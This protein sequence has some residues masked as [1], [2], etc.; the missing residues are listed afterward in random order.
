M[1]VLITGI[2]G[3][4]GSH[5]ADALSN[6]PD[7]RLSGTTLQPAQSLS[8]RSIPCVQA[9]I[10]DKDQIKK[11]IFDLAPQK[12]FH[13]AGQA[14]VPTSVKD[15]AGTFRT[16]VNGSLNILEAARQL[17]SERQISCSVLIVSSSE[18]YGSVPLERLPIDE[19]TSLNP[20]NPYAAS[21]ACADLIAQQYRATFGVDV[22]VARPFNHLGPRQSDLFVGSALARQIAE[23]MMA[24]REP[25]I[26]VGNLDPVRDFTDVRDVVQ[27]YIR[28]LDR[29]QP[30]AVFNVCSGR[31]VAIGEILETL[32]SLS[33]VKIDIVQDPSRVRQNEVSK[34]IGSAERLRASTAWAPQIPLEQTL[35]D[36]LRYWEDRVR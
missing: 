16:N 3:F 26:S 12:L 6:R 5:L 13:I 22:V 17:R 29:P 32:R 8:Q 24:K 20:A 25:K 7:V 27:A 23:I 34:V 35:Q 1:N 33:G 4:V 18:I 11:V 10:T 2:D 19:R 28:L 30:H 31:G 21:K 15:P 36:L 9:D 14:F